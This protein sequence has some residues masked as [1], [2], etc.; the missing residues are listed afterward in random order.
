MALE[1]WWDG[2]IWMVVIFHLL[3]TPYTKV[4]ESFNLQACHD[5]L[6]CDL[7]TWDHLQFPGAVPRSFLGALVTS[8][9]L[10][11][12]TT[13]SPA[14]LLRLVRLVLASF[15]VLSTAR[16]RAAITREW[17]TSAARC[18]ALIL[19]AQ[20]HL[21]FYMSRSLPNVFALQLA[22]LAHAELM[23]PSIAAAYRCLMLLAL[24]AAIFR[25]DLLLL[26]A[27]VGLTLLWQRRVSFWKA[28]AVTAAAAALGAILSILV[29]SMLWRR[30]LWPEFEVLWLLGP[31]CSRPLRLLTQVQYCREPVE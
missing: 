10:M 20:F 30:W 19:L 3:L 29:D 5:A 31:R 13:C 26:I 27:P 18:F 22:N 28:A 16:L 4:E 11:P 1:L 9:F 21:P 15:S 7:A 2:L 14:A 12:F 25:C 17:G 24:A 8:I 23:T 6:L